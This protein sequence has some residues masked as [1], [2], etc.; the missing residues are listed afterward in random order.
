MGNS[1]EGIKKILLIDDNAA[2]CQMLQ[3]TIEEDVPCKVWVSRD[4]DDGLKHLY[5][6]DFDLV[7]TDLLM[8]GKDGLEV[9]ME[10]KKSFSDVPVFAISGGGK[11]DSHCSLEIA[12]KLGAKGFSKPLSLSSFLTDVRQA[13][14]C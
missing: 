6:E 12:S 2:F 11:F 8:P 9:I 10:I 3:A 7:I 14:A 1:T 13:I 4:G 5:K